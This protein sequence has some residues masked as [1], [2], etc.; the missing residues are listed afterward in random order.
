[1]NTTKDPDRHSDDDIGLERYSLVLAAWWREI[2]FGAF[3]AAAVGGVTAL[4]LRV[5]SPKYEALADVAIIPTSTAVSIDDKFRSTGDSRSRRLSRDDKYA[6]RAALLGLVHNGNIATKVAGKLGAWPEEERHPA[7]KLLES[8]STEMI[9][10]GTVSRENQSDL[11]R[12]TANADSPEKAKMLSDRWAEEYV[13]TVNRLYER[14]PQA[15]ITRVLN[16]TTVAEEA[17][18]KIQ[19]ELEILTSD[20][21]MKKQLRQIEMNNQ[22]IEG[23]RNIWSQTLAGLSSE[24]IAADIRSLVYDY[25]LRGRLETFIKDAV[26]LRRQIE[27]GGEAGTASNDLAIQLFKIQIYTL[28]GSFPQGLEIVLD[29][30]N[31]SYAGAVEQNKDINSVI[32]ALRARMIQVSSDIEQKATQLSG[33]L[34]EIDAMSPNGTSPILSRASGDDYSVMFQ[35]DRY[36]ANGDTLLQARIE[37]LEEDNGLLTAKIEATSSKMTDLTAERDRLRAAVSTLH[38]ETIELQLAASAAPS[39]VRLASPAAEPWKSAWPS[40]ALAAAVIGTAWIPVAMFLALLMNTL[41][42]QPFLQKRGR[43]DV[44]SMPP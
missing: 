41:G 30:T 14:V 20:N 29:R 34:L 32:K 26:S 17:Y 19:E 11:I 23:Y 31:A 18:G 27:D 13:S 16:Q 24:K 12:I 25:G 44:S 6:R 15:L 2:V 39:E 36:L 3:L 38:N 37:Q 42:I 40:P 7:G 33:Q 22:R 5:V 21:D 10:I 1:M 4:A 35:L 9:T 43:D 28:S 8:I